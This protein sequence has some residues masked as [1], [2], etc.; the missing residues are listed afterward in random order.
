MNILSNPYS[1]IIYPSL[2]PSI[3]PNQITAFL[4]TMI[5]NYDVLVD[6]TRRVFTGLTVM[7]YTCKWHIDRVFHVKLD[8]QNDLSI[9]IIINPLNID[10]IEISIINSGYAIQYNKEYGYEKAKTFQTVNEVHNEID[11]LNQLLL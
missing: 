11:R 10:Q 7:G 1:Y 8:G 6:K 2:F 9:A 4:Q 3:D 5:N